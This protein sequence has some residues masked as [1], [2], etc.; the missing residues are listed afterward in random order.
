MVSSQEEKTETTAPCEDKA[1]I[2]SV[3]EEEEDDDNH[4]DEK[5]IDRNEDAKECGAT[6]E[7][8]VTESVKEEPCEEPDS[9]DL[10]G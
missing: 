6:A 10:S 2:G 7:S 1:D 3:N 4:A 8:D 9:K 5:E